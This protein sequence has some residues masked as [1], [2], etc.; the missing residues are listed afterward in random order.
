VAKKTPTWVIGCGIGCGVL[1]LVAV[2]L[3]VGG[4]FWVRDTVQGFDDAV[5][6]RADLEEQFGQP[7]EFTPAPDGA[8]PAERVEAFLSVRKALAPSRRVIAATF[9]KMP[10]S[11]AEAQ[12]L[13]EKPF[14]EKMGAVLSISS[15]AIGLASELGDLFRDRNTA[16]L[17]VR[18]GL[19]EYTYIYAMAYYALLEHFPYDGPGPSRRGDGER[20]MGAETQS[21]IRRDLVTMLENQ[22]ASLP[23]ETPTGLRAALASEIAALEEDDHRFPWQD[24]LPET[25]RASLEPFR[26]ELEAH[27]EPMTN[28]FELARSRKSGPLSFTAD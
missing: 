5:R 27:Y 28:L 22:L 14:L 19:G 1:V 21:R 3:V 9:G 7:C 6:T 20:V 4:T 11:E 16:M 17:E 13:D 25:I 2:V 24:S 18:M 15:S 10:L 8:I 23:D 26:E 12:E